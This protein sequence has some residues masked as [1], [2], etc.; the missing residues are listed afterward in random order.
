MT[1]AGA[2]R[3]ASIDGEIGGPPVHKIFFGRP[4]PVY[5]RS[6]RSASTCLVGKWLRGL[7]LSLSSVPLHAFLLAHKNVICRSIKS[8]ARNLPT[9]LIHLSNLSDE[10]IFCPHLQFHFCPL[11]LFLSLAQVPDGWVDDRNGRDQCLTSA[12]KK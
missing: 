6:L 9:A 12:S 4:V 5:K 2:S 8:F 1:A 10:I 3:L 11:A 7:P